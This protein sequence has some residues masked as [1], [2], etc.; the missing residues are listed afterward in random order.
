MKRLTILILLAM[1][2]LFAMA[3]NGRIDLRSESKA[4]CVKSDMTSLKASFSFSSI[5]AEDYQTDRGLFS[6]ISIPNTVIGGNEGDPQVP[7]VNELIAIPVGATPRIEVTSYSVTDYRLEDYGIH[8][9]VP[10]QPSLRKDLNPEDVPFVYNA[11]AYQTRGLATAPRAY[12]NVDGIMRGVRV[13]KI[14]RPC[15]Q[16]VACLQ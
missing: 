5:Q 1:S 10:R 11:A 2:T 12:V 3:Q 6:W 13:G 15:Q 9:L 8:T 14:L 16:Y 7:V 4:E